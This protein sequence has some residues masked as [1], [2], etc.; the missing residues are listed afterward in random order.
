MNAIV[1]YE[2][3]FGNTHDVARAIAVGLGVA[4]VLSTHEAAGHPGKPD[5]VVV[6]GPTHIHGMATERSRRAAV[7]SAKG[8][9]EPGATDDPDLRDW[10]KGLAPGDGAPA[11]AF[12][13]RAHGQPLLTG[14][15]SH[16]IARRLRRHGYDVL[17]TASFVV[18][19]TEGPLA[20]DELDRAREWGAELAT[21]VSSAA[22]GQ[23]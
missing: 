20:E 17:A 13:T 16:G 10:L 8:Q 9:T 23:N 15:A 21:L 18:T 22:A 6:G 4:E 12:D 7:E 1:V 5:L 19:A 11:A 14:A 2:S 3:I